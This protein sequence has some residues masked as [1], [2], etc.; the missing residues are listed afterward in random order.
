MIDTGYFRLSSG[1]PYDEGADNITALIANIVNI[2]LVAI[3]TMAG[4]FI[5]IGGI[6]LMASAGDS[7]RAGMAKSIITYNLLAII[8]ALLSYSI[9][10]FVSWVLS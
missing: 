5:V 3:A 8:M 6:I 7:S 1:D 9:I 4:L 10:Q 2:L